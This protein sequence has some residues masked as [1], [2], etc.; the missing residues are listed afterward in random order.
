[1]S[2]KK[3]CIKCGSATVYDFKVPS[4]C[5]ECGDSFSKTNASAPAKSQFQNPAPALVNERLTIKLVKSKVDEDDG[6]IPDIEK[7]EVEVN[8]YP[9]KGETLA[10]LIKT[11]PQGAVRSISKKALTKAQQ[12]EI[13]E[14]LKKEGSS[15]K[16]TSHS[17]GEEGDTE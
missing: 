6:S 12:K 11:E 17:V 8:S 15:N 5:A 4:F 7:L 13:L 9:L 3:Y 1:M 10:Q 16:R 2:N 14:E